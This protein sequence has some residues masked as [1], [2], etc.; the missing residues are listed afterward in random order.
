MLQP[1][2]H[3]PIPSI[4]PTKRPPTPTTNTIFSLNIFLSRLPPNHHPLNPPITIPNHP[5]PKNRVPTIHAPQPLQT[6]LLG[7]QLLPRQHLGH[8]CDGGDDGLE[9]EDEEREGNAWVVAEEGGDGPEGEGEVVEGFEEGV[10][11]E[12][13]TTAMSSPFDLW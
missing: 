8:A 2:L 7:A 13:G 5:S 4:T 9:A 12:P 11:G 1:L 6:L 3:H 10:E